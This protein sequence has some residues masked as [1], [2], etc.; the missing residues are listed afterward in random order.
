M[1]LVVLIVWSFRLTVFLVLSAV[2]PILRDPAHSPLPTPVS[3]DI[4]KA[5][6]DVQHLKWVHELQL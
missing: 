3:D 1:A 6:A 5:H 4:S 2:N